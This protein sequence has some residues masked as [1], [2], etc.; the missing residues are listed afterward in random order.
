MN[1]HH[2]HLSAGAVLIA[3][4]LASCTSIPATPD[5]QLEAFKAASP[6][7]ILVVPSV[8]HSLFVEAPNYFLS[9]LSIPIANKGY[10]V[11]PVNTVKVVLEQEGLYEPEQIHQLEP[12]KLA[13]MFGADAVLYVTIVQWTAA[14]AVLTTQVTVELDYRMVGKTNTEIWNAHKRM[15]YTPPQSNSGNAVANLIAN[16]IMAAATRVAPDYMPLVNQ[17]NSAVFITDRTALPPGPYCQ[18]P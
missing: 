5:V 8:N 1:H 14:Y 9:S 16:M 18:I 10:Y 13:A 2:H 15:V 7:S 6:K 17:A 11:F 12:A 4:I 3:V